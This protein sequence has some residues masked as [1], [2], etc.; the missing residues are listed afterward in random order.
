MERK[1]MRKT[2]DKRQNK[3]E[4]S[5]QQLLYSNN[6]NNT[7]NIIRNVKI[8]LVGQIRHFIPE[9]QSSYARATITDNRSSPERLN[10]LN[11]TEYLWVFNIDII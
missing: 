3:Q 8:Y 5:T 6:S 7:K 11:G 1:K 9:K 4:Y 10:L 2:C